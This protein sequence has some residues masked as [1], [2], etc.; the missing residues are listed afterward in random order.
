[1]PSNKP[2]EGGAPGT[3]DQWPRW[4]GPPENR[5]AGYL[6]AE[7]DP[8]T[9]R[10]AVGENLRDPEKSDLGDAFKTRKEKK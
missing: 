7:D 9:D 5:P 2:R 1:M 3:T 10:D 6:P 8:A 4:E